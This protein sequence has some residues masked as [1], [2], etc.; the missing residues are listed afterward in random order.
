V[1]NKGRTSRFNV[2]TWTDFVAEYGERN[3]AVSFGHYCAKDFFDEGNYLDVVRVVNSDALYSAVLLKD[4]GTGVTSLLAISGGISDPTNIAWNTWT[5]GGAK[6]MLLFYPKSGPGS[7]AN[8]I[9][10]RVTSANLSQMSA[11]TL[12]SANTGGTLVSATY[13]YKISAISS[14]GETLASNAATVTIGGSISTGTVTISWPSVEGAIGY[15]VYGRVGGSEKLLATLGAGT[16]SFVDDGTLTPNANVSPITNPSNLATPT[17]VFRV[18]VYDNTINTSTP[19]ESWFCTLT[20]QVDGNGV[21]QEATQQINAFSSYIN[22]ASYASSL[23]SLPVVKNT[24]NTAMAGGA[25][26]T[27]PTNSQIAAAWTNIFSD[28]EHVN[29]NI[30][31]NGG[32]SSVVVQQAMIQVASS[33][34][35]AVAVLDMPSTMQAYQDAITYRQL[36]LN[37]NTSY[38]AIYTSDVFVSDTYNGKQLYVPPSGKVAAVYA[39]TDRV[40]GPQYAPAGLNRGQVDVLSLRQNYN[41]SQRTQLFQ[42]QVNYLRTFVGAGT[43]VFEQVTLQSNQ[44][45]LSWVNVRRMVNTIKGGVKDFLMYSLQEPNDDFLRRQ[46]VVALTEYLQFWKD[47]RG[48]S[49]FQV[50]SDSSNNPDSAYNLGILKVTVIITPV[51]A[52][53]EIGVDIVITKAGVSFK[54]INISQL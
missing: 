53:H 25:S 30:L 38:A 11:P 1:S 17:P 7:Y 15:N 5:G 52:V 37:A 29:V 4:D 22:C 54:E 36:V 42:T 46:I 47:A 13:S 10:I 12:Q 2:T 44:S 49:D 34:G 39:R 35:D 8:S 24:T 33:R 32:Y 40:A 19:Q 45:A 9:S 28:R 27:A 48:I 23:V 50:I 14:V 21:Q 16:L 6:P 20:D 41:D 43:A 18:D 26:G 51:I 31:I 3:A